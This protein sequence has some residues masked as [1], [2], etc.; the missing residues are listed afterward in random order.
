ML[1]ELEQAGNSTERDMD[2]YVSAKRFTNAQ[3]KY[4]LF[5]SQ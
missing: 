4:M 5:H 3:N 2:L 1:V